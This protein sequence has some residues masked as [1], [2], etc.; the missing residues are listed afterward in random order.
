MAWPGFDEGGEKEK[1]WE[2]RGESRS[3]AVDA[4]EL[5]ENQRK[6]RE[7]WKIADEKRMVSFDESLGRRVE[8]ERLR[9]DG[10]E[11]SLSLSGSAT[12]PR[13]AGQGLSQVSKPKRTK[14]ARV[15]VSGSGLVHE[16]VSF[17]WNPRK[18]DA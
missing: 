3:E 18:D 4:D 12:S 16:A 8:G 2:R 1:V 14:M 11:V 10:G 7:E 5:R 17:T 15:T 6:R 13:A 9:M